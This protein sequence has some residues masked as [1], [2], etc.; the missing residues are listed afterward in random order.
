MKDNDLT[1]K[2]LVNGCE[3]ANGGW[4]FFEVLEINDEGVLVKAFDIPYAEEQ[5]WNYRYVDSIRLKWKVWERFKEIVG[6]TFVV[7][8]VYPLHCLK[9]DM[10][11]FYKQ[12]FKK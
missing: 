12:V 4:I 11:R 9:L 5:L 10:Q 1:G 6:I 2:F 7:Y 3:R 8:I